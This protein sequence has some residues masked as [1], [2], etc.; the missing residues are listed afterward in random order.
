MG[1][2]GPRRGQRAGGSNRQPGS[3][4]TGGVSNNQDTD[5]VNS[6][7]DPSEDTDPEGGPGP[8]AWTRGVAFPP[9]QTSREPAAP[10]LARQS[11]LRRATQAK[12]GP[13]AWKATGLSSEVRSH[14]KE[15]RQTPAIWSHS[16]TALH[17]RRDPG[18]QAAHNLGQVGNYLLQQKVSNMDANVNKPPPGLCLLCSIFCRYVP[19]RGGSSASPEQALA[20]KRLRQRWAT[21]GQ[22]CPEEAVVLQWHL[23]HNGR[24]GDTWPGTQSRTCVNLRKQRHRSEPLVPQAWN[25]YDKPHPDPNHPDPIPTFVGAG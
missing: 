10:Q 19:K 14:I 15:P 18:P 22:A 3:P 23:L 9:P 21:R 4:H 2:H 5:F 6:F 24:A 25:K 11:G 7:P 8:G 1:A 12:C 20:S 17:A 16:R 13:S